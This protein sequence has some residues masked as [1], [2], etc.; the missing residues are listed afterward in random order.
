MGLLEFLPAES[1]HHLFIVLGIIARAIV[2]YAESLV[3]TAVL[4]LTASTF[5][6]KKT[7]YIGYLETGTGVGMI[8]GPP[9]G[10]FIYGI[11]GYAPTFYIFGSLNFLNFV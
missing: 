2:G 11:V 5:P 3:Q 1:G 6:E 7:E 4:S 10:S 8:F 9:L